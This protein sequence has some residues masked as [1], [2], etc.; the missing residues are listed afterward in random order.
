MNAS[1]IALRGEKL[2]RKFADLTAV[3][4]LD[5]DVQDGEIFGFLGPNGAGKTTSIRMMTGLLRPTSG[6]VLVEGDEIRSNSNPVKKRIGVCPQEIVVWEKLTC[7]ENVVLMGR[8]FD[9]AKNDAHERAA[10]LLDH[11][12]LT[13]K[14][15]VRAVNLSGGMQKRL[16]L[17]MALVHD[18][19]IIVLDEP[20]TGLDPQ[21]R[22]LVSEFIRSLSR[23]QG[24]TVILTTHMMEVAEKLSDRIA[25]MD[26]GKLLALDTLSNLK[27][28]TGSGDI[29]EISVKGETDIEAV[30]NL[31]ASIAGVE[32]AGIHEGK[33]RFQA[34]DAINLLPDI[35]R[36]IDALGGRIDDLSL[37][38]N[39]LEDIFIYLTGRN[40][41]D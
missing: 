26:H 20:I 8:M 4:K 39:T 1:A 37:H 41:R 25:I 14:S 24:K 11:V 7:L 13:H 29:V 18:P 40:L 10:T 19:D 31:A 15:G 34:P 6:R 17:V 3:D 9:M 22:L 30:L 16:N 38:G 5:L 23:E 12:G 35:S 36:K 21:S 27:K 28:T 33:V 2:T 32:S